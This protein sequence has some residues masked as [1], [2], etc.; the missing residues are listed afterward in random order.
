[1]LCAHSRRGRADGSRCHRRDLAGPVGRGAWWRGS[2]WQFE[3][4]DGPGSVIDGH[5]GDRVGSAVSVT[6]MINGPQF[7]YTD[8]TAY[9]LR[10]AWWTPDGWHFETL[11][12]PGS[13]LSGRTGN[14]VGAAVAVT[15]Y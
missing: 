6:E 2:A 10:H 8:A 1:M 11:D 13:T 14:Q 9:S 3:T 7:C 15:D 12:G 5:D 4:L